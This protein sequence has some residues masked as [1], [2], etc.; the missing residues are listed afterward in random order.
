[1]KFEEEIWKTALTRRES[2][3]TEP[4]RASTPVFAAATKQRT[5]NFIDF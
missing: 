3:Q 5:P 1:M 4:D 2:N